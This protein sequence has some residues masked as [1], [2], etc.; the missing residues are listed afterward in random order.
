MVACGR[1]VFRDGS[2]I[3]ECSLKDKDIYFKDG[4]SCA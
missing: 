1:G 4:H 3:S 2:P